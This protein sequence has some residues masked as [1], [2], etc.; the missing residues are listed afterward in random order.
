M[1]FNKRCSLDHRRA[2]TSPQRGEGGTRHGQMETKRK[3]HRGPPNAP[4]MASCTCLINRRRQAE[5]PV[6]VGSCQSKGVAPSSAKRGPWGEC[7][8]FATAAGAK[9]VPM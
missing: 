5:R 3:D 4:E 8:R 6:K 2:A 9:V 1:R 7:Y